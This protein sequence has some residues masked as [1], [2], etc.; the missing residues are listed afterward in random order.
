[1][2]FH[3]Y[4]NDLWVMMEISQGALP[5]RPNCAEEHTKCDRRACARIH[6]T[7]WD[8]M[9]RCWS[10][11]AK[12]RPTISDVRVQLENFKKECVVESGRID[13]P[14]VDAQ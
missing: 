9:L 2:P 1:M 3:T 11:D 6:E 8:Y 5:T 4:K 13:P 12:M 7:H 14:L 10:T